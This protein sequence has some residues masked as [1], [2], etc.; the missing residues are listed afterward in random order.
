MQGGCTKFCDAY[1]PYLQ[2][3]GGSRAAGLPV[4]GGKRMIISALCVD[5]RANK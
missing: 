5:A 1:L 2:L 3:F 4:A